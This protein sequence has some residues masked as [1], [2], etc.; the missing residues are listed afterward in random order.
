MKKHIAALTAAILTICSFTACKDKTA[1]SSSDTA[2]DVSVSQ[3]S[4]E[5]VFDKAE[6]EKK[7]NELINKYFSAINSGDMETTL[8]YQYDKDDLEAAAVMSSFGKD[9]A[10]AAEALENM[11]STY[12]KAYSGHTLTL[13]SID[14]VKAVPENG[15]ELLDELYGRVHAVKELIAQNGGDKGLDIQK[16][17]DEYSKMTDTEWEKQEYEEAYL[18][19]ANISIDDEEKAQEMIIFRT[20]DS[21]WKIDM[22]VVTYL[23]TTAQ[24]ERDG[25]ASEVAY[26]ATQ[27]LEDMKNEG[28]DIEGTYIIARDETKNY[29][30]P[31]GFDLEVFKKHFAEHNEIGEGT[32]Y[33]FVVSDLATTYSVYVDAEGK[34]GIYPLGMKLTEDG[35]ERMQYEEMPSGETYDI[36]ELYD[37][38]KDVVD[39]FIKNKK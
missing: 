32:D 35:S 22:T 14:D 19:T 11:M 28:Y 33:F 24:N 27:A 15:Y 13:N 23:E 5:V 8:I 18:V 7:A 26:A 21:D 6:G 20:K 4:T 36:D 17:T 25:V 16:I 12:K 39:R 34:Q 9:G 2:S 37:M 31:D 38:C 1:D 3:V 30:I 29:L 10:T